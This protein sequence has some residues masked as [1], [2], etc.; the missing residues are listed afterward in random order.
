M[1]AKVAWIVTWLAAPLAVI[2]ATG[3]S[4]AI[5]EGDI[6]LND[7]LSA[8]VVALWICLVWA[9]DRA[10]AG[11]VRLIYIAGCV[12]LTAAYF[13]LSVLPQHSVRNPDDVVSVTLV[14]PQKIK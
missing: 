1:F 4:N 5:S 13:G 7:I 10:T 11:R 6:H 12:T 2:A 14:E 3:V 9:V 8:T